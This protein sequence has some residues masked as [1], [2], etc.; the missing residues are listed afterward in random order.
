MTKRIWRLLAVLG[1]AAACDKSPTQAP[2]TLPAA[3]QFSQVPRTA[4]HLF[5]RI[6]YYTY[7]SATKQVLQ[8]NVFDVDIL[9]AWGTGHDNTVTLADFHGPTVLQGQMTPSGQLTMVWTDPPADFMRWLVNASTGC[10]VSG[11]FPVWHGSFDGTR[12]VA[13]SEFNSICPAYEWNEMW[14][15]PVQGGVHWAWSIDVT[16][17]P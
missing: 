9:V 2:A 15:T 7:A 12:M 10:S 16:V 4:T 3:P 17:V 11:Q 5:G 14:A 6:T 8:D 1:A 13:A